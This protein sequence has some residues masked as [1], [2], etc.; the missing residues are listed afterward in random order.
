MVCGRSESARLIPAGR[1]MPLLAVDVGNSRIKWSLRDG[2]RWIAGGAIGHGTGADLKTAWAELPAGCRAI[3]SNVAGSDA[4]RRVEA[5]LEA[6][7]PAMRWITSVRTQCGVRNP[8]ED[9][10][11]LGSDRWAALIAAR[12][13]VAGACLVVNAGTAV[14]LDALAASGDFLGGLI[15]PGPRLMQ[16]VLA[17][18]T[19][20]LGRVEGSY[21]AFPRSTEDAI[22]SGAIEAIAGALWR[23]EARLAE[24]AQGPVQVIASGGAMDTL[25]RHLPT[26]AQRVENLVLEGLAIIAA[27]S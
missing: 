14:T 15:L 23:M 25:A 4:A 12:A 6:K 1:L 10:G 24:A 2:G 22:A 5:A 13:M 8:Y 7:A 9:P 19:A 26:S 20:Q 17:R 21:A 16:E 11:R 3:G 27:E 18:D